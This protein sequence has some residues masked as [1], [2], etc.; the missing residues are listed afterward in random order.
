MAENQAFAS[1]DGLMGGPCREKTWKEKTPEERVEV[2]AQEL[3]IAHE[4]IDRLAEQIQR[5]NAHSHSPTGEILIPLFSDVQYGGQ[6]QGYRYPPG[7]SRIR[8]RLGLQASR[9]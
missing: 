2:L 7:Y 3:A 4:A 5:M 9:F 6:T 1:A 8:E